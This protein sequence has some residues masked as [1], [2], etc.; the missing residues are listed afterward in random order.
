MLTTSF[1]AS[2]AE[3]LPWYASGNGGVVAAGAQA[4]TRAGIEMLEKW[5]QCR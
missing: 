4:A 1:T 2:L 3:D 5:R